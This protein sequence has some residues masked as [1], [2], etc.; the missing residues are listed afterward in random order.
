VI[1]LS[2][3]ICIH[4]CNEWTLVPDWWF[5]YAQPPAPAFCHRIS[6]GELLSS[7]FP[8][9][10]I[11]CSTRELHGALFF[12]GVCS[13]GLRCGPGGSAHR[14]IWLLYSIRLTP[15]TVTLYVLCRWYMRLCSVAIFLLYHGSFTGI[16][17]FSIFWAT[18]AGVLPADV[19]ARRAPRRTTLLAAR[20]FS[21]IRCRVYNVC[22]GF[23]WTPVHYR[24]WTLVTFMVLTRWYGFGGY[25]VAWLWFSLRDGCVGA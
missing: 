9:G 17:F 12:T 18:F 3:Y 11:R 16:S 10:C 4:L 25:V 20:L 14:T 23:L 6:T 15:W 24:R 7:W 22:V 1:V 8:T 2:A 13:V 19:Y 21:S 5:C